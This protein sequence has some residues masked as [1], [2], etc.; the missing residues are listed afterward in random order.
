MKNTIFRKIYV[1]IARKYRV[2]FQKKFSKHD[3]ELLKNNEFT[4]ISNN[5]WG[6]EIYKYLKRPFNTPFVGLYLEPNSYIKLLNNFDDYL[7]KNLEFKTATINTNHKSYY[8]IGKLDDVEIHFLHYTSEEEARNK[9]NRRTERLLQFTNKNN[10][11]VKFC[12]MYNAKEQHFIDFKNVLFKNKISFSISDYS[13]LGLENH[14]RVVEIHKKDK[15]SVPNGVKLYKITFIYFN[16]YK[17]FKEVLT[18]NK[19]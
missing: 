8:P 1:F 4:I 2:Y 7:S 11:I 18:P 10:Y 19:N 15:N 12:D 13:H 3:I 5:C 6:G 16:L 17:W 9:W 14:Y